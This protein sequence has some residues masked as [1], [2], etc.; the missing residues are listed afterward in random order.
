MMQLS[1]DFGPGGSGSI[2][3]LG[4]NQIASSLAGAVSGGAMTIP[5]LIATANGAVMFGGMTATIIPANAS[6]VFYIG[7]IF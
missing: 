7:A 2:M 4:G 5:A 3:F 1:G 6:V